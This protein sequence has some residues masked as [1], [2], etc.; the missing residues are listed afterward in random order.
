MIRIAMLLLAVLV[1]GLAAPAAVAAADPGAWSEDPSVNTLLCKGGY[2]GMTLAEDGAGGVVLAWAQSSYSGSDIYAQRMDPAGTKL[3]S[4]SG[5]AVCAEHGRRYFVVAAGDGSGGALIA[6]TD[7]RGGSASGVYAQKLDPSGN[8]L[9]TAG[10]AP[11]YT[12][13]EYIYARGILGDGAGGAFVA[14]SGR[15]NSEGYLLVQRIDAAGEPQWGGDG[16]PVLPYSGASH[17]SPSMVSDGAGGL[18]LASEGRGPGGS[19]QVCAAR[20]SGDG[21]VHWTTGALPLY[22]TLTYMPRFGLVSDGSGGAI[23]VWTG[24][25]ENGPGVFAQRFD[26][27]GQPMWESGGML[28]GPGGVGPVLVSDGSGGALAAW[29]GDSNASVVNPGDI[30]AQGLGADGALL[31]GAEGLPVCTAREV[32][33]CPVIASDGS[34]GA[35]IAWQDGRDSERTDQMDRLWTDEVNVRHN[36]DI[37]AQRVS[38]SGELKWTR[39]GVPVCT[40]PHLQSGPAMAGTGSGSAVLIWGDYRDYPLEGME[41][42]FNVAFDWYGQR[43]TAAGA[44]GGGSGG[45]GRAGLP[46]WAWVAVA[47]AGVVLASGAALLVRRRLAAARR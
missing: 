31:W 14:W 45:S 17:T 12:P 43:V 5:V 3:W 33:L 21:S 7:F 41:T 4:D 20:V 40:A 30:H 2:Y 1:A 27:D 28:V 16:I 19:S 6:W 46:P 11:V 47:A 15:W 22:S 44:L 25:C 38:P 37:Y 32:Q 39:D 9:W 34:G 23:M 42:D 8:A 18:I 24:Q 26:G 36:D 13:V 29:T 35:I 10:G